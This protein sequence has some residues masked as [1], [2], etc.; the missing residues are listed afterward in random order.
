MET[1]KSKRANLENKRNLF[2]QTGFIIVLSIVLAA[3]E[4]TTTELNDNSLGMTIYS[5]EPEEDIINTFRDEE[6][7]LKPPPPKQKIIEKLLIVENTEDPETDI[8]INSE[9]SE[10][11]AITLL[12]IPDDEEILDD[13]IFLIV[14]EMPEFPGGNNEMLKYLAKE[15]KFNPIAVE[16]YI[17]GKVFVSFVIDKKG[18]V[19]DVKILRGIDPLLDNEALRVVKS[20]PRWKPGK[21]RGRLVKVAFSVPINFILN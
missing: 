13:Q 9:T 12:E 8:D 17:S 4:W 21:Q 16:S 1:K 18:Y 20:M 6:E 7:K 5:N 10:G 19:T 14:E 11:E 15:T 3:F 2:L